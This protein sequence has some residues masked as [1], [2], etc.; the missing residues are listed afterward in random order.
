VG[1]CHTFIVFVPAQYVLV[2]VRERQLSCAQRWIL[3]KTRC[4]RAD[5]GASC[6]PLDHNAGETRRRDRVCFPDGFSIKTMLCI[7]VCV[8][9]SVQ[10]NV[11]LVDSPSI[12]LGN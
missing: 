5:P 8:Y 11:S 4:I 10:Y 7:D 1:P 9:S 12:S 3:L 6:S 2:R